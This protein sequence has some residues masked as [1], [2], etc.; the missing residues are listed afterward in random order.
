[1]NATF[2]IIKHS[3]NEHGETVKRC[4]IYGAYSIALIGKMTSRIPKK[5]TDACFAYPSLLYPLSVS[6]GLE[7]LKKTFKDFQKNGS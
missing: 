1:M 4:V 5:L 2:E 7:S 6:R 3:C